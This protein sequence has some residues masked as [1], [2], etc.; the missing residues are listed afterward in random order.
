MKKILRLEDLLKLSSI[1]HNGTMH[2]Y[3][4]SNMTVTFTVD[5][6][7]L[8]RVNEEIFYSNNTHGTPE[9]VDEIM[10]NVN[11]IHFKYVLNEEDV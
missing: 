7:T 5:E 1:I 10:I 6:D 2:D 3:D 4:V 8:K 9:D 11:D